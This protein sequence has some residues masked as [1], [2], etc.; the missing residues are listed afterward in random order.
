MAVQTLQPAK[1]L[2]LGADL[3]HT[4]EIGVSV[5]VLDGGH[6]RHVPVLSHVVVP[7]DSLGKPI[8]LR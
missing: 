1:I 8:V 2:D 6:L 7:A 3:L 5:E 4:V